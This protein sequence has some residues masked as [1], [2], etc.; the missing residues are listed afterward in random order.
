MSLSKVIKGAAART[1][2]K[3]GRVTKLQWTT[4]HVLRVRVEGRAFRGRGF[5][6]GVKI[7]VHVGDGELRSYTPA[8]I[9]AEAGTM[10]VVVHVHGE[11][12][13]CVWAR[14]LAVGDDMHFVGPAPSMPGPD[15]R[16]PWAAFYGDE[17]T[18]G[19]AEAITDALG[20]DTPVFGAIEVTPEDRPAVDP[21]RLDA[22]VREG[23]Y[24]SALVGHLAAASLPEGPGMVWLSG[25]AGSVLALRGA[26]LERGLTRQQLRIKPYWSLRGKAHRKELERTV[27]KG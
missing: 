5:D 1:L 18:L 14:S 3:S 10:D 23:N 24:G 8:A 26:L 25:E 9:D 17:T 16:A 19:L 4:E 15:G 6:P 12:P 27:L 20:P 2:G 21:L 13:A 11:S 22:V 7:K